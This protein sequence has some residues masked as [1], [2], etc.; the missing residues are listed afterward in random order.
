MNCSNKRGWPRNAS[1]ATAHD[2]QSYH[3]IR[4]YSNRAAATEL[5]TPPLIATTTFLRAVLA[6]NSGRERIRAGVGNQPRMA[7]MVSHADRMINI[8]WR[9][10]DYATG[11]SIDRTREP[12]CPQFPVAMT[13]A[14]C[15]SIDL[16]HDGQRT[17]GFL[18]Y[19]RSISPITANPTPNQAN[20]PKASQWPIPAARTETDHVRTASRQGII[21]TS[22]AKNMMGARSARSNPRR[23]R[24][25]VS[26]IKLARS[27]WRYSSHITDQNA[28]VHRDC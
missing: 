7:K 16:P 8:Q 27:S 6:G 10:A 21:T 22:G 12:Q 5:S 9:T 24:R 3:H 28:S 15:W 17:R 18:R 13:T 1:A 25:W 20:T 26:A 4:S 23:R 2:P 19:L 11:G 14:E